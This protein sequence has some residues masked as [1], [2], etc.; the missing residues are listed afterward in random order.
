MEP[1]EEVKSSNVWELVEKEQNRRCEGF[2]WIRFWNIL[3]FYHYLAY[4]LHFNIFELMWIFQ[5][6]QREVLGLLK[7]QQKQIDEQQKQIECLIC[8]EIIDR[9]GTTKNR[10]FMFS[11]Q[12]VSCRLYNVEVQIQ[13]QLLLAWP[14]PITPCAKKNNVLVTFLSLNFVM[15]LPGRMRRLPGDHNWQHCKNKS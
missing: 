4:S 7:K 5:S 12:I 8:I 11:L 2:A 13:K 6:W 14:L 10:F 3:Y 1:D 15:T 9:Q